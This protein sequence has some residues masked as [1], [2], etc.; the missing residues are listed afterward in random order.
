MLALSALAVAAT[1]GSGSVEA[2]A[3]ALSLA[4]A[5]EASAVLVTILGILIVTNEY[6]HGT[7]TPTF[8]VTPARE[9]VLG[10]KLVT[11]VVAAAVAGAVVA[12]LTVAIALPWLAA[13]D[14]S[15]PV[16]ADLAAALARMVGA[17]VLWGALGVVVG[18]VVRSQ[19]GAIVGTF[20]WFLIVE[21]I[22]Y[23]LSSVLLDGDGVRPYLPGS[24]LDALVSTT[25]DL[26]APGWALLLALLYVCVL[27]AAGVALTL[28]RDPV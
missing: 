20:V 2:D 27:G 17:F 19:I 23:G 26:L 8:L 15:L 24:V 7:I 1:V 28:R 12:A 22:A 16:D 21:P 4:D 10:A 18:A 5:A 13:R 6:R 9:R 25:D 14:E 11:A 3:A